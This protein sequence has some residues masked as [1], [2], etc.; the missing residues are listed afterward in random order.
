MAEF[1]DQHLKAQIRKWLKLCL[2]RVDALKT[3]S[4]SALP[5]KKPP[6]MKTNSKDDAL[7]KLSELDNLL[8]FTEDSSNTKNTNS[9][10]H[11]SRSS[12]A[13]SRKLQSAGANSSKNNSTTALPKTVPTATAPNNNSPK[14]N[15]SK[16][17]IKVSRL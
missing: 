9:K 1:K 15:L 5:A 4:K 12:P 16:E 6:V 10:L 3:P 8:S 13:P 14:G 17:E 11:S 7:A 2:D